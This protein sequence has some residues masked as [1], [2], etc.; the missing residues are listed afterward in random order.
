M[1]RNNSNSKNKYLLAEGHSG[2]SGCGQLL[3]A[4]HVAEAAGPN[5]II[6][7]STGCLEVTTTPY[8]RSAWRLPWFHSL[9]ENSAACASGVAAALKAQGQDKKINIIAQG[10]DGGS[11]DIGFGLISGM[12]ERKD[13]VLY[14]CYDNEAYMNTGVQASGSTMLGT[15]TT[16]SPAGKERYGNLQHKKN[17]PDIAMAHELSYVAVTT[18]GHLTDLKRKVQKALSMPGA[19]YIQI[20]SPCTAGWKYEDRLTIKLCKLAQQSGIYPVFEAEYG[21]ITN[22]MKVP[23]QKISVEDYLKPQKRFAHLFKDEKGQ[24]I[25][26]EIQAWADKNKEK[27]NLI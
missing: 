16:T 7:N 4:R 8:P 2:C 11:F 1:K 18:V 10:G 27:Y 15:S 22:S 25:I 26:A 20:L 21:K 6:L 3:A 19:K 17:L 12:W 23:K 5:T 9:F 24:K 13:N 14:I